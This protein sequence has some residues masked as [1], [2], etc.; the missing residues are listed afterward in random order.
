MSDQIKPSPRLCR[1]CTHLSEPHRFFALLT[2]IGQNSPETKGSRI[3]RL[4]VHSFGRP[5]IARLCFSI[6]LIH[7]FGDG[8]GKQPET[9][10]FCS[11]RLY[12]EDRSWA[13]HLPGLRVSSWGMQNIAGIV[14]S[15]FCKWSERVLQQGYIPQALLPEDSAEGTQSLWAAAVQ[16]QDRKGEGK[17]E[18][19][20]NILP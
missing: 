6:T 20:R 1:G 18:K 8:D 7:S 17:K 5:L 11:Q 14:I 9:A 13:A 10:A 4:K 2:W 12:L 3:R 15:L 16:L 19:E